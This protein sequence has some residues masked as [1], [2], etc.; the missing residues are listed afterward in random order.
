MP[1]EQSDS[2]DKKKVTQ[3]RFDEDLFDRLKQVASH[4]L[5]SLNNMIEYFVKI[6]VEEYERNHPDLYD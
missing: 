6:G 3:A 2:L 1:K 4:E 5:R